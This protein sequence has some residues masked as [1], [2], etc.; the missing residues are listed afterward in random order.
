MDRLMPFYRLI[1]LCLL[2]LF[3]QPVEA[4]TSE[5]ILPPEQAFKLTVVGQSRQQ[6]E[7]EWRIEPGYHLY[8]DKTKIESQTETIQL[9]AF[10]L[11]DGL[12]EHDEMFGDVSVYRNH[13]K[14]SLP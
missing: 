14:L 2:T 10:Q 3:L 1:L 4:L 13:L 12:Q 11:P 5:D 6:V 7:L 8:R 9:G